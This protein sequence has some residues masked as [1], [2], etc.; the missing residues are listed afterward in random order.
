M[1]ERVGKMVDLLAQRLRGI[2][3][4]NLFLSVRMEDSMKTFWWIFGGF[5]FILSLLSLYFG[6]RASVHQDEVLQ[7]AEQATATLIDWVP[8]PHDNTSD[9]CPVYEFT[10][11]SGEVV[12]DTEMGRCKSEPDLS[13]NG[14]TIQVYFNPDNPQVM[15]SGPDSKNEGLILGFIG[16]GFFS[17]FWVIPLLIGVFRKLAAP[18]KARQADAAASNAA[19]DPELAQ[20]KQLEEQEKILRT[21][22]EEQQ[23][24]LKTKI[25]EQRGQRS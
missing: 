20:L 21:K 6:W 15:Y 9:Y 16:F 18:A 24:A 8:D 10:A 17:L 19:Y 5:F 11:K 22:L 4:I 14:S 2:K 3:G 25:E 7:T 12:D 1:R 23:K 13:M